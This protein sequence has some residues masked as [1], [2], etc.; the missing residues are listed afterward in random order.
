MRRDTLICMLA[1]GL[2]CATPV[3]WS[4]SGGIAKGDISGES[5]TL[6]LG[7]LIL[8]DDFEDNTKGPLWRVYN[9]D[10]G[11]CAIVEAASRL[12]FRS[13]SAAVNAFAGYIANAWRLDPKQDFA[14]RAD[15]HY[16]LKTLA[17]GWVNIGV[18]PDAEHP[19]QRSVEIGIGCTNL[20]TC[21]WYDQIDDGWRIESARESRL[22]N[23]VALYISYTTD[24]DTLYVSDSGY[25]AEHAWRSFPGLLKGQWGGEPVFVY[26]GG[27][28]D[29][30]E[31]GAGRAYL[32]NLLVEQ[33]LV[34]E[35]ALQEVYRFWSPLTGG[36]FYTM[37]EWEKEKLLVDYADVWIYEGIG[38]RAYPDRSDPACKPV[39]RFWSPDLAKHFYT[40]SES[41]RQKVAD[42]QGATWAY[43]GVA[44]Y[45]YPEGAQPEWALPV[46]RFWSASLGSHFYT[47]D[48]AERDKVVN[49]YAGI[50]S[51]EGIAWYASQ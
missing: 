1:C 36:H 8:R 44:F 50:W 51:Y 7:Q 31:V 46:Y 2:V 25:G 14:F 22:T 47:M 33:G 4:G 32:D 30:L 21:Y 41:E 49:E 38:Y 26:L 35:A 5:S 9:E 3:L 15:A 42:E 43:E 37:D 19:R 11:N 28:S 27:R 40:I 18:A 24:D 34:V 45:A 17:G 13:T 12:E 20:L 39:Y 29:G 16:D 23:D 6:A 10:P 48:L